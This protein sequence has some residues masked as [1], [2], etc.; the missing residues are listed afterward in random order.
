MRRNRL[1]SVV[2]VAGVTVALLAGCSQGLT[3]APQPA[4]DGFPTTPILDN[5]Q[6]PDENPLSDGGK[7]SSLFTTNLELVSH[8]ALSNSGSSAGNYWNPTTFTDLEVYA[9]VTV[10]PMKNAIAV[11]AWDLSSGDGYGCSWAPSTNS[12]YIVRYDTGVEHAVE[13]VV[14]TLSAGDSIGLSRMGSTFTCYQEHGGIWNAVV[15]ATDATYGGPFNL[16]LEVEDGVGE[17]G[18]FGGGALQ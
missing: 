12:F 8:Q 1:L 16:T 6:R 10:P 14:Q 15:A 18:Y 13:S 9:Q 2:I 4:P 3:P 5:F 11:Q 17:F 7:W